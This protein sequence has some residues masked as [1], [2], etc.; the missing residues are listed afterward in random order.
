MPVYSI[1]EDLS[2]PAVAC[3]ASELANLRRAYHAQGPQ[4]DLVRQRVQRAR[5]RLEAPTWIP[6]VGAEN[7][8]WYQCDDCQIALRTEE[9][10]AEAGGAPKR[11]HVCPRCARQYA[12]ELY[13]RICYTKDHGSNLAAAETAAWAWAITGEAPFAAFARDLLLA[14]ADRYLAFPL[15][16]WERHPP[17]QLSHTAAHIFSDTLQE[18]MHL[19]RHIAPAYD[20]VA[21]SPA[22]DDAQRTHVEQDLIA[23]MLRTL[24]PH[25]G[26]ISNWQSWHDAALIR[27]GLA[28]RDAHWVNR[29][30]NEHNS[31][32]LEQMVKSVSDD[33]VWY[34][35]SWA[36]H[37][38]TI[39]ALVLTAETARR[40]G[41]DLWGQERF[42]RMFEAPLA[43][44]TPDGAL[45]RFGDS[46]T[47]FQ[48]TPT[49]AECAW[50]AWR[51][52]LARAYLP[53]DDAPC[54]E[55]VLFAR[56]EPPT[57]LLPPPPSRLLPSSGHAVLRTGGPDGLMSVLTFAQ[58][59]GVHGHF[60]KLSFVLYAR[61]R[62]LAVDPGR[63]SSYSLPVHK[64]WYRGTLGHNTIVVDGRCAAEAGGRGELF[65]AAGEWAAASAFCDAAYSN[66]A[67]RRLLVQSADY[68]LVVDEIEDLQG[69]EHRF[70]WCYHHLAQDVI[71]R[72]IHLEASDALAGHDGGEYVRDVRGGASPAGTLHAVFTGEGFADSLIAAA[73][74]RAVDPQLAADGD[75]V[76]T[77]LALARGPGP[78]GVASVP[79]VILTRRGAAATFAVTIVPG[80]ALPGAGA[81]APCPVADVQCT[82]LPSGLMVSVVRADGTCDEVAWSPD[83][84]TVARDG[85]AVL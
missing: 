51:D 41:I 26:D 82:H 38:F 56:T 1:P 45:P 5:A 16:D 30:I 48:L 29:A 40:M 6:P 44:R 28:I 65:A 21:D 47:G 59:G 27:G 83:S 60:D 19:S 79:M 53:P 13:D 72:G 61:G 73:G 66:I 15:H 62:E 74:A 22:F 2:R 70:D 85:Q 43:Y 55:T 64:A 71:C 58:H 37:W 12:G 18:S 35:C 80:A 84:L 57:V 54:W 32:F 23:A 33:G 68:L 24:P 42:R 14:Y 63:A 76:A 50:R 69:E 4:G 75:A 52:P 17:D 3:D 49:D 46:S 78:D 25:R 11:R 10:G 20:L 7:R 77:D 81:G 31:G 9:E 36:Y 67:H 34:E 39:S 8:S